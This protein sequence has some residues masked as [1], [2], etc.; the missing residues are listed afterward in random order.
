MSPNRALIKKHI[1]SNTNDSDA[2]GI[3]RLV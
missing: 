2:L 3:V 1:E